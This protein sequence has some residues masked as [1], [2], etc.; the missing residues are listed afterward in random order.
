MK[1]KEM[2]KAN[3]ESVLLEF[4]VEAGRPGPAILEA[5][6]RR[7][8]QFARELTDYALDW[9][10]D[11]AMTTSEPANDS[12]ASS[13]IVSR[14]ISRLYDRI[15]ER[16]AGKEAA[17]GHSRQQVRN[18]FAEL[19]VARKRTICDALGINIPLFAKFQNRLIDATSVPRAFL[20]RFAGE[21]QD[22]VDDLLGYLNLPAMTNP[23]GEFKAQ[24]K[25]TVSEQKERFEDAVRASAL[26]DKQKQAL[27]QD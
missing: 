19:S 12:N 22:T 7:Y 8:P 26:D 3:L 25:P 4:R 17:A 5:Y 15:R 11:E 18:P 2:T 16:E 27:L 21:L 10:V 14:A 1:A 9:L 24:G 13:P 20:Q 23:A 6:C